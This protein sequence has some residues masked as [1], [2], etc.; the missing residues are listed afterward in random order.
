MKMLMALANFRSPGANAG[1]ARLQSARRLCESHPIHA[2]CDT[3]KRRRV[4]NVP[5]AGVRIVS[6]DVV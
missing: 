2:I 4:D 6:R 3:M 1:L 5:P